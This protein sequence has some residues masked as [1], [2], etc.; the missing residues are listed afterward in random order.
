MFG[1]MSENDM[2]LDIYDD[3]IREELNHSC[4]VRIRT[5]YAMIDILLKSSF[6]AS[7]NRIDKEESASINGP[8]LLAVM[9][10]A[11][12]LMKQQISQGMDVPYAF[13]LS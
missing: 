13:L 9:G 2:L 6:A 7:G 12:L 5:L 11:L 8:G 1:W 4:I 10:M 3:D